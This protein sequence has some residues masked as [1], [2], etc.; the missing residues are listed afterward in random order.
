MV[1]A[2]ERWMM[3]FS[4]LL[5][6]VVVTKRVQS[7]NLYTGGVNNEETRVLIGTQ[8]CQ[9]KNETQQQHPNKRG[10]QHVPKR[11]DR[12]FFLNE[13][14][15]RVVYEALDIIHLSNGPTSSRTNTTSI[16]S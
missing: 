14:T 7:C 10:K 6:W 11:N 8:N 9:K 15:A 16:Q 1:E 5:E 12:T 4:C 2:R 3:A 13:N